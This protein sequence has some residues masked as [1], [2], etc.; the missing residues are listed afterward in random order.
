M[1][2]IINFGGLVEV[3]VSIKDIID[4]FL[5]TLRGYGPNQDTADGWAPATGEGQR[6]AGRT[7]GDASIERAMELATCPLYIRGT[8]L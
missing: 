6:I 3:G 2:F 8:N 7:S 5:S 4:V 1:V